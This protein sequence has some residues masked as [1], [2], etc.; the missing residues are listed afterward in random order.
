MTAHETPVTM[1]KTF[2][3]PARPERVFAALTEPEALRAWHCEHCAVELRIGGRYAFW[4]RDIAWVETEARATQRIT[5]LAAPRHLAFSWSWRDV[6]G[7]VEL[8]LDPD[9]DGTRLH[10]RHAIHGRI[11]PVECEATALLTDFWWV[12]IGNLRAWLATGRA[13]LRT[14]Y[15]DRSRDVVLSIE[16]DAPPERIYAA[17]TDPRQLD[18]WLAARAEIDPRPGGV[19]AYGWTSEH[20]GR[21][22]PVGPARFIELVPGRRVVHDWSYIGEG[23]SQVAWELAPLPGGR[24]RVTLR[25]IFSDPYP[26]SREGYAQGW[27]RFLLGLKDQ[28][29]QTGLLA[30]GA[31]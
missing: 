30:T 3:L 11:W 7:E 5:A 1:H 19:Y 2:R 31:S 26:A 8:T 16:I 10:V 6:P 14:D 28:G 13:A 22:V 24:T 12:A 25:H 4:G 21:T 23:A 17:L 15:T 18:Q 9:G 29:E 20:E 27:S